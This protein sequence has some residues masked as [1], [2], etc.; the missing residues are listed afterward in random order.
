MDLNRFNVA[1][2]KEALV[3][4]QLKTS[5]TKAELISRLQEVDAD[6][7]MPIFDSFSQVGACVAQADDADRQKS[8]EPSRD[9]VRVMM[10]LEVQCGALCVEHFLPQAAMVSRSPSAMLTP[11]TSALPMLQQPFPIS[12]QQSFLPNTS[13]QTTAPQQ[14]FSTCQSMP[15][16]QAWRTTQ[17]ADA[18]L[19]PPYSRFGERYAGRDRFTRTPSEIAAIL[20]EFNPLD[21]TYSSTQFIERVEQLR[22]MYQWEDT[23]VVFAVLSRLRGVAKRWAHAQP[24]FREWN[25]FV[26]AFLTDFPCVRNSADAHIQ[27]MSMKM[28]KS[29]KLIEFYYKMLA[30]GRRDNIE[31]TS[32]IRYIL[33][34]ISDDSLRKT[35]S[36]MK[37]T[38]CADLL[39]SLSNIPTNS[40]NRNRVN[41]TNYKNVQQQSSHVS[42]DANK[43]FKSSV[44]PICYNCREKGHIARNCDKAKR[45]FEAKQ[46]DRINQIMSDECEESVENE[47]IIENE[48]SVNNIYAENVCKE[49]C[50]QIRIA[51]RN[52]VECKALIDSGSS[53]SLVKQSIA[54]RCGLCVSACSEKLIGFA[55]GELVCHGKVLANIKM[56]NVTRLV[57]LLIVA[58]SAMPHDALVGIDVLSKGKRP[59][60]KKPYS[61]PIPKQQVVE[62]IVGELLHLGVIRRSSSCY[63]SPVVLVRKQNGEDRLCVD[64]RELNAIT[65]KQPWLM[66]TVD[67][68]LATLSGKR[69][70]TTLD[71][72]SGYYQIELQEDAKPLTAFVTHNGHYEFNRM[73][74]GLRNAPC[75]F[76]RMM[77]QL[78]APLS[79][80]VVTY[81]DEVI[82]A[83]DS[84]EENLF[85]LEEF[86]KLIQE[87]GLTLRVSK[88]S[89]L[90]REVTFLGHQVDVNGVRPGIF[91]TSAIEAYPTPRNQLEIRRFLGL[92]GFFRKFVPGFAHIAEPLTQLTKKNIDFNWDS[93]CE[94]AFQHL[95]KLIVDAPVLTIYDV[96]KEHELH[97]DA[98][99]V[100]VAA[101]LLQREANDLKPIAYYSR[102]C[103]PQE[104]NFHAY[105]LE[106]LA[107]VEACERFKMFLLGK[108]FTVITDCQAMTTAKLTKPMVPRVARWLLKLLE[109]DY[110]MVHRSGLSM[111]H[112]DALSRAPVDGPKPVED[113]GAKVLSLSMDDWVC[114]M[115]SQDAKVKEVIEML[116][117]ANSGVQQSN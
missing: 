80:V 25:D 12:Q 73:P 72:M 40:E 9:D 27:M 69:F 14:V 62:G 110:N 4:L 39:Q 46:N 85:Y 28:N 90:R 95:I 54:T 35:L 117:N 92:T 77:S 41:E 20:P 104:K 53:K 64:Y 21:S 106:V 29:E 75:V 66:P 91:K 84:E 97:T 74:F 31:D 22:T 43:N 70:F 96:S 13:Q 79:K 36:A 3:K 49:L 18:W 57:E 30:I 87:E 33:N 1:Q 107:V 17:A 19:T 93:S 114:T 47:E 5:G 83:T 116:L 76:Q 59:I 86:L 15:S 6:L 101:I 10:Q 58:D 38:K 105:E 56:D 23:F 67:G 42:V 60:S 102:A 26:V 88:C 52:E 111:G 8:G 109:Y 71:L 2:L 65:E 81:V 108:H 7:V 113:V 24:A 48:T 16:A 61:V 89:F 100:G 78:V 98:S 99:S 45:K 112:V 11:C 68:V 37:F 51:G 63:A 94:E 82:I 103:T 50:K 115:Q 32:I 55:G 44:G 34:G